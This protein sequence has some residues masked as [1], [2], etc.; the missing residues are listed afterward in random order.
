MYVVVPFIELCK[1][2]A[3]VLPCC[4]SLATA[5]G[6]RVLPLCRLAQLSPVVTLSL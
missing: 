1:V 2:L 4:R 6:L 3:C 5:Y